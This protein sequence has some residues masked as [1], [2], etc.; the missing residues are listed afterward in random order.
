M[1]N[2]RIKDAYKQPNLMQFNR[3]PLPEMTSLSLP[4]LEWLQE[5]IDKAYCNR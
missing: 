3:D 5:K 1:R 4:I 2:K